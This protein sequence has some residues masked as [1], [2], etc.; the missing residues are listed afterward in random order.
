[1]SQS[2]FFLHQHFV[3]AYLDN[4]KACYYGTIFIL[5]IQLISVSLAYKRY[6]YCQH[7][8]THGLKPGHAIR[9]ST[10]ADDVEVTPH[11]EPLI[12]E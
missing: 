3:L 4:P 9:P 7:S 6:D 1:M 12:T 2:P 11:F 8:V 5:H 10:Y